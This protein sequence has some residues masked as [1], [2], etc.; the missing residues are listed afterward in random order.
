MEDYRTECPYCRKKIAEKIPFCPY[1]GKKLPQTLN[2]DD[3]NKNPYKILQVSENAGEDVIEAA[4]KSLARKYH[5]DSSTSP[6]S[7]EK[8]REIN[9]AHGILSDPS[10]LA[11]WKAK[12]GRNQAPR[13]STDVKSSPVPQPKSANEQ[14]PPPISQQPKSDLMDERSHRSNKKIVGA[15][16]GIGAIFGVIIICALLSQGSNSYRPTSTSFPTP[17]HVITIALLPTA[18]Y[19]SSP[20][21]L[22]T[23]TVWNCTLWSDLTNSDVGF[24]R[25]VY[26]RV[27]KVYSTDQYRQIIR[28][29]NDAGTFLIWDQNDFFG[30]IVG[31]CLAAE[32][33]VHQNASSLFMYISGT[34]F[35]RVDGCP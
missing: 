30:V 16:I 13:P 26:G 12:N 7:E 32:G 14:R 1:C 19:I 24:S 8:M 6:V 2:E 31:D 9:W 27:V 3:I 34:T 18:T 4:Y 29:S 15:I 28:F 21:V 10:K 23:S 25:C 11:E 22:P 5:P 17:T 35:K 20:I 33:T